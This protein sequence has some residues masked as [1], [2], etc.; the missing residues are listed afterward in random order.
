VI[1]LQTLRID[2]AFGQAIYGHRPDRHV[3]AHAGLRSIDP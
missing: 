2:E 3:I 1:S